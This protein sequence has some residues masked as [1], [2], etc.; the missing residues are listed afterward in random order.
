MNETRTN[1]FGAKWAA[2]AANFRLKGWSA[3]E[4]LGALLAGVAV[5]GFGLGG[6][7]ALVSGS[8]FFYAV[9]FGATMNFVPAGGW[10]LLGLKMLGWAGGWA[11][12]GGLAALGAGWAK[13]PKPKPKSEAEAEARA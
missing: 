6:V 12:L 3:R 7:L 8:C 1:W 10:A 13:E 2:L 5:G 9:V 11:A 4:I